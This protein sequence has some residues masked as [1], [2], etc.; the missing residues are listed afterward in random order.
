MDHALVRYANSK[1]ANVLFTKE[2]AKRLEGTGVNT[3]SLHPGVILTE[4]TRDLKTLRS[5]PVQM[6]S[7]FVYFYSP[8][9][10]MVKT[11][12]EGAQT[13]V[14]CAVSEEFANQSGLYYADCEPQAL[15][16]PLSKDDSLAEGF[17]NWSHRV[18]GAIQNFQ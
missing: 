8:F 12:E 2:L 14:C 13:Q 11:V 1:L 18:I 16:T 10:F 7:D 3:Y 9:A 5:K 6:L 4:I 17:W 15:L